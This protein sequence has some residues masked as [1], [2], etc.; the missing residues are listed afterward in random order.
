M[1]NADVVLARELV[2]TRAYPPV[3]LVR[4]ANTYEEQLLSEIALHKVSDLR[5]L[6]ANVSS[7]EASERIYTAL[8]R[9][10]TNDEFVTSFDLKKV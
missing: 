6:L 10:K 8:A 9:T 5:R 4:S 2:E 3:D 1:A 7:V